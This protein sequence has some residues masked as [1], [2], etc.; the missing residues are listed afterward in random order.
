MIDQKKH[1]QF[2]PLVLLQ[3]LLA[4]T[5]PKE[6]FLMFWDTPYIELVLKLVDALTH[7]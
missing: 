4:C 3:G 2:L 5:G 7:S 6:L 1:S